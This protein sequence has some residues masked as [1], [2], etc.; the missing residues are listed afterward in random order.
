MAFPLFNSIASWFL[1]KRIHQIE[2]FLKY[3]LEVQQEVLQDLISY[4]K[5]TKVGY[6]YDFNSIRT[7]EQ[8]NQRVPIITY[9]DIAGDI[10][11]SRNGEDNIF[12]LRQ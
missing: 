8:F 1:K 4:A 9:E 12:G 11:D 2:L 7:Y 3:P 10:K 5:K 6:Q